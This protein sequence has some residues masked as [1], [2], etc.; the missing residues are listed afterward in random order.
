[1][2]AS[3]AKG[4][5]ELD[6][7]TLKSGPETVVDVFPASIEHHEEIVTRLENPPK[8][9]LKSKDVRLIVELHEIGP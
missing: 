1:L 5:L 6:G 2:I 8:S 9:A 3:K 4:V 7:A